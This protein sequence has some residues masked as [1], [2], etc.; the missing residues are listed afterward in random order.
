MTT[1]TKRSESLPRPVDEL[2]ALAAYYETHDTTAEM[3]DAE[4]VDPRPMKTTSLRLPAEVV[5]ALKTLAHGRGVR[6]TA[7]LRQIIEEAL[8]TV[9]PAE[10]AELAQINERLARIEAAVVS[11]QSA[12]T[13][14]EKRVTVVVTTEDELSRV[15]EQ[16]R[17]RGQK[18]KVE[19][20]EAPMK[21]T[22]ARQ[23]SAKT[24][25]YRQAAAKTGTKTA[26]KTKPA[27]AKSER[28]VKG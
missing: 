9:K 21:T 16:A 25:S 6:Y 14:P 20:Q 8:E 17:Q 22:A 26:A 12:E 27:A 28:R 7:L 2:E 15:R 10:S 1:M 11:P 23:Q 4:W 13:A 24:A 18:V 3:E 5:E 19:R